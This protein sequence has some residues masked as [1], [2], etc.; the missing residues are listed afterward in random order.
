MPLIYFCSSGLGPEVGHTPD[1]TK[2]QSAVSSHTPVF[3]KA[4]PGGLYSHT[5]LGLHPAPSVTLLH[6]EL[7]QVSQSP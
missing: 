1:W 3:S 4:T 7:E 2:P 5:D 6:C